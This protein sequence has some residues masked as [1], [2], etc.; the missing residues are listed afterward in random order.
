MNTVQVT[1]DLENGTLVIERS[2]NVSKE[3][4]WKAYADKEWFERW[5]GPQG[6][7]TSVKEFSFAPGGRI[8]YCMKCVDKD[9]GEYFGQEAWGLMVLEEID[10]PNRFT[11]MDYF[12]DEGG[13]PNPDMPSQK[14]TVELV[15]EGDTTRLVT[16]T[17]AGS[18]EQIEQLIAMGMVE[19]FSSQLE[20]LEALLAG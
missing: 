3:R 1:K 18:K 5:W 2:F 13:A 11:A 4:L 16:R 9:Q 8:H 14:F 15:E 7:E 17:V 19:G 10:A 12:T 20:K 6:W